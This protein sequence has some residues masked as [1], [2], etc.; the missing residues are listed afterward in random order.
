MKKI[1]IVVSLFVLA[2]ILVA[3]TDVTTTISSLITSITSGTSPSTTLSTELSTYSQ[4]DSTTTTEITT[5]IPPT[6]TEIITTTTQISE[7]DTIILTDTKNYI[8][9]NVSDEVDLAYYKYKGSSG[10]KRLTEGSFTNLPSGVTINNGILKAT[11]KGKFSLNFWIGSSK[12]VLYLYTKLSEESNYVLFK[13]NFDNLPNGSLPTGYVLNTGTA[14]INN[15]KLMVDGQSSSNSRV[16]LPSYLNGFKDYIIETDF[17]ILSANEPTRWASVMFRYG[18]SGYFQMAVRQ[19]ANAVNGV[20]F[21]K[22]INNDWNVPKTASFNETISS[23]T[24]Y[25]LKIDVHGSV[26]KEYING[27]LMITYEN[28]SEYSSG[29][30][31]FQAKG[32]VAAYNNIL[33]S[34]PEDYID[35]ASYVFDTI[36]NLYEPLTG[37]QIPPAAMQN[38]YS[39]SDLKAMTAIVRPQVLIMTVDSTGNIINP[40]TGIEISS[41]YDALIKINGKVIPAFRVADEETAVTVATQLKTYDIDDVF[42][43]SNNSVA[44]QEARK[45]YSML[46]GVLIIDYDNQTPVL[47]EEHL[48]NIRNQVNNAGAIAALLPKEYVSR[49]NVEYLQR[50]LVSVFSD[51]SNGEDID[52]YRAVL[53]GTNGLIINNLL[54]LYHFFSLFPENSLI[55]TPMI[56]GHRGMP[57]KAPENTIQGSIL[58]LEAGAHVIELDIYLTTD[59]RLAVIHDS[60]TSRT[61]NGNLTVENSSMSQLQALTLYDT[62]GNYPNLKIPTLD[63]YFSTF[64]GDDVQFFIEIKSTKAEIVPI[65]ASAINEYDMSDRV[66]VITF[67][68]SQIENMHKTLPDISTGYLNYALADGTDTN[69]S[70]I[71]ILNSIIPIKA[72]YNPSYAPITSELVR[73]LNY[74]GI[75]TWPWKINQ[76][77]EIYSYYGM[78][79]G[80]VTTDYSWIMSDIWLDLT[81]DENEFTVDLANPESS[82]SLQ[83]YI[84]TL[85]GMSQEYV[86]EI[87]LINDG[88]TGIQVSQN[89]VISNFTSIGTATFIVRYTSSFPNST[90]YSIY[91]DLVT[92]N[93]IDSRLSESNAVGNPTILLATVPALVSGWMISGRRKH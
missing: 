43:F 70:L 16:L 33:I 27:N 41:I 37:I 78:G 32:A 53:S 39:A 50:R 44:I 81:M 73:Q 55:R 11:S 21:A 92:I 24:N 8:F 36:A 62:T 26:V 63:D 90:P 3:C 85:K 40:L 15:G 13:A 23:T 66:T 18:N 5:T 38:V 45:V 49:Y 29:S 57:S 68:P 46:R 69:A 82:L 51:A 17:T 83:G 10:E 7:E 35:E 77:E 47:S 34:L 6:T 59:N 14:S 25:R 74:R 1:M 91:D 54:N 58:A 12:V 93:V 84:E 86:P 20:E 31:G 64:S 60:T 4:T 30:I 9:A 87:V 65:L 72:T 56:I 61:A 19:G 67:T 42:L 52:Q 28:A 71:S 79:V 48:I 2:I 22:W 89:A 76:A 80:G 88:G 75:T